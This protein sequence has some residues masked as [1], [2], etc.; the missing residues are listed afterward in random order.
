[1]ED[2]GKISTAAKS[3]KLCFIKQTAEILYVC[4]PLQGKL[5]GMEISWVHTGLIL[6]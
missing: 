6:D 2:F 5:P 3:C 1:V 4:P